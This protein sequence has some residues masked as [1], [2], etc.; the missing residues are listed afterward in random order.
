MEMNLYQDIRIMKDDEVL[1]EHLNLKCKSFTQN[2]LKIL[3][4]AVRG[5]TASN[6]L[7]TGGVVRSVLN[8]QNHNGLYMYMHCVAN[9]SS[10]GIVVGSGAAPVTLEDHKL[11]TQIGTGSG[12]GQLKYQ[13]SNL[14]FPSV[15][16]NDV[17]MTLYRNFINESTGSVTVRET[18]LICMCFDNSYNRYFL[19]A[20]DT[21]GTY[22]V[23]PFE[24]I[25]IVYKIQTEL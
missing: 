8:P 15:V 12:A 9:I 21:P 16:D 13:I 3:Y 25:Q 5:A 11:E 24:N 20:R 1:E 19:V 10:R 2:W 4:A 6:I 18:G 22:V 14:A 17:I 23:E 7:D